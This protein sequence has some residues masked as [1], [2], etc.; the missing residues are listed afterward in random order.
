MAGLKQSASQ[1][2]RS[3]NSDGIGHPGKAKS[4]TGASTG[5]SQRK[6]VSHKA[7]SRNLLCILLLQASPNHPFNWLPGF[8][9]SRLAPP[10]WH[11]ATKAQTDRRAQCGFSA[12]LAVHHSGVCAAGAMAGRLRQR[13]LPGRHRYGVQGGTGHGLVFWKAKT[14]IFPANRQ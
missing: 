3:A 2:S 9:F 4:F 14:G 10:T 6:G 8:S 1:L 5:D 13:R 11:S 7:A 12:G